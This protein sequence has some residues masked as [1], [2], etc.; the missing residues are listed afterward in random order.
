M[1]QTLSV[2]VFCKRNFSVFLRGRFVIQTELYVKRPELNKLYIKFNTYN[3]AHGIETLYLHLN[4]HV[5]FSCLKRL[6]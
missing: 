6:G 2:H 3:Y 1:F 4:V 5:K